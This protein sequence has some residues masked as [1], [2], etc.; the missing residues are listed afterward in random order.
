M[1]NEGGIN[2][3]GKGI[4]NTNSKDFKEL[5]KAIIEHAKNQ[6]SEDKIRYKLISLKLQMETYISR[7][8]VN[9]KIDVGEFLKKHLKA[10]NIKNKQFA[11]YIEV[12]ESNLS[13]II[14]GR[15]K[16]NIDTAFK[17]GQLFNINPN[18]W[19]L[20]Q[21]KNELLEIDKE[22]RKKYQKYKLKDLLKKA[23]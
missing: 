17:L 23:G 2:G 8:E 4:V 7:E 21:S 20:I 13:S 10:I 12:E 6:S 19:L 15:R 9:E 5:Q 14:N 18:L 11:N 22:K 1:V 16:I 3:T